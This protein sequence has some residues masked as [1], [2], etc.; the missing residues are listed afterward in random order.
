MLDCIKGD[1]EMSLWLMNSG[2]ATTHQYESIVTAI[3]TDYGFC[4]NGI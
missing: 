2:F 4:L 1:Y 3:E